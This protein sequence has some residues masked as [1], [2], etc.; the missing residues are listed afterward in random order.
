MDCLRVFNYTSSQYVRLDIGNKTCYYDANIEQS[1]MPPGKH[2][3]PALYSDNVVSTNE[4]ASSDSAYLYL[5]TPVQISYL[6]SPHAVLSLHTEDNIVSGSTYTQTILPYVF[7]KEA[8]E[9]DDNA[10]RRNRFYLFC[11]FFL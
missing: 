5:D 11:L 10:N 8:V 7:N 1:L 9:T 6:S 3:Y 4:V 2:K